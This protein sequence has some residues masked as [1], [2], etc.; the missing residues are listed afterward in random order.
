MQ[1]FREP[2]PLAPQGL[3]H[4]GGILPGTEIHPFVSYK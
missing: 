3:E 4:L 2:K 1:W